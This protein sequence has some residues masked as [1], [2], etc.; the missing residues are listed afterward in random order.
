MLTAIQKGDLELMTL[1]F[2]HGVS[3]SAMLPCG[4]NLLQYATIL[5]Q[6]DV[7]EL[8]LKRGADIDSVDFDN[9][10]PLFYA[11]EYQKWDAFF[12]LFQS[13]ANLNIL[14]THCTVGKKR[15]ENV[16]ALDMVKL[17]MGEAEGEAFLEKCQRQCHRVI[18]S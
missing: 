18:F 3:A 11:A 13:G 17:K 6:P 5:Y 10:T 2:S 16:S 7:I 15:V 4:I 8:L 14:A 12:I 1:L 9:K